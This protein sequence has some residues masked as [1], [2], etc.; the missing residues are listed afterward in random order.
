MFTRH[1]AHW[2]PNASKSLAVPATT[3]CYNL[4]VSATRYPDKSAIVYY[5]RHISFAHLRQQVEALAGYLSAVCKVGPG[6]RV[7]L[8]CQNS[9]Q[10][11]IGYYAILRAN[12][13][14]VPANAMLKQEELR[15]LAE[16]SGAQTALF[17][18]E[19]LSEWLPLLNDGALAHAVVATYGDYLPAS[20]ARLVDALPDVVIAPRSP[21]PG[22]P[23]PAS[24][25]GWQDALDASHAPPRQVAT[26]D[27]LAVLPYTSGTTGA[28]KGCMHT[29]RTVMS[30]AVFQ[31]AWSGRTGEAVA[32]ATLPMFH[33][34]GM[35]A[36]MNLPI[37]AGNTVV[38]MT[39]WDRDAAAQLIQACRVTTFTGIT[40]MMVDFLGNPR[41]GEYDLSSLTYLSGGGAAMPDAVARAL[42]ERIGL[43]FIEGYGLTETIA[44]THVNPS[45]RPKRQC[46]GIPIFHTDARVID[47][48]T[49]VEKGPGE[50]GEIVVNGPQV[51]KGYWKRPDATT[52]AFIEIDGKSFFRTGDLGHYDEEG[53]F[54]ITDRLKR[55]INASG[56]KVWPAEVEAMLYDHPAV[57]EACVIARRDPHRGET[58][59]AIIVLKPQAAGNTR[60]QDIIDW[61]AG[62]MAAYK[63]PKIVEFANALPKTGTG[64]VFWRKLQEIENA[65]QGNA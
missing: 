58:V 37:L 2:P 25:I 47:V 46:A 51:F 44:P 63:A 45:H 27:D 55:M 35:Q 33:V 21:L 15:Y 5:G 16:D 32:L 8:N 60:P 20:E 57:S 52:E 28:P 26:A 14:V 34:T 36:N 10:F 56:F 38:I 13:V 64:K 49:R 19:I 30:T 6:D 48:D 59:K 17:G 9:P 1:F 53:Y 11:V 24:L 18:Q 43:P 42:Q 12:A 41:L 31:Q 54:F 62:R 50:T 40:A 3:L 22:V 7:I 65:T 4:D 61:A 23:A 39:R 29:H